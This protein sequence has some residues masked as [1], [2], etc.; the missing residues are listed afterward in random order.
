MKLHCG[1]IVEFLNGSQIFLGVHFYSFFHFPFLRSGCP[2]CPPPPSVS[3]VRPGQQRCL[4][5][6]VPNHDQKRG[7][8]CAGIVTQPAHTHTD[9]D[10]VT[11][12]VCC[13]QVQNQVIYRAINHWNNCQLNIQ[14][15]KRIASIVQVPRL[16][17]HY[18]NFSIFTFLHL[19]DMQ[20]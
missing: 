18:L 6:D 8:H 15:M 14:Y 9:T 4:H 5:R 11:Q 7:H 12:T 3:C 20:L 1:F 2:L 13:S 10:T 19:M 17:I 16:K